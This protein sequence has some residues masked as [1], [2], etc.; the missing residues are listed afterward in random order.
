MA[1]M[2]YHKVY[3]LLMSILQ[4]MRASVLNFNE[5]PTMRFLSYI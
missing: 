2:I 1:D 4:H 5:R 3:E